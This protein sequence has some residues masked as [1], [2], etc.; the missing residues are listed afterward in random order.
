M[1]KHNSLR[2]KQRQYTEMTQRKAY[3]QV[4]RYGGARLS[5]ADDGCSK[6]KISHGNN[7]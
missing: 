6:I 1:G 7:S 5:V 3:W 4:K 2:D